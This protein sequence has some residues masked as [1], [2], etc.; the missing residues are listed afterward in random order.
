MRP[1]NEWN[2]KIFCMTCN[3]QVNENE[4]FEGKLIS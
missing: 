3:K 4:E 2:D 1:C